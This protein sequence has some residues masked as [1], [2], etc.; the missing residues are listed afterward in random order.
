M[1]ERQKER[2]SCLPKMSSPR[3]LHARGSLLTLWGGVPSAGMLHL[4]S[5][6]SVPPNEQLHIKGREEGWPWGSE[7]VVCSGPTRSKWLL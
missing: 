6:D 3:H 4:T 7:E 2:H 1:A 5:V